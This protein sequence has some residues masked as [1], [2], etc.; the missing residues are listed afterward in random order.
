MKNEF[1]VVGEEVIIKLPFRK[2]SLK[3]PEWTIID[4]VDLEKVSSFHWYWRAIWCHK[5][6]TYYA[7]HTENH[8]FEG[9]I[10]IFLHNIITN[11]ISNKSTEVD[12]KDI[13]SLNNKRINLRIVTRQ[14]N[15]FNKNINKNNVSGVT[16][17]CW[18]KS[19]KSWRAYIMLNRVH[20]H[21]G[22][23][24]DKQ[25]AIEARSKAEDAYKP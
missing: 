10:W 1:Y 17:V 23:F 22:L 6:N 21:L 7:A 18:H 12:H 8:D 16:G 15:S 5:N 25:K 14:I 9:S 19:T 3:K 11:H 24:K 20:I 2:N 13:D 4:L